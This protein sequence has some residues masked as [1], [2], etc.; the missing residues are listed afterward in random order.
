MHM[1]H[2]TCEAALRQSDASGTFFGSILIHLMCRP[3]NDAAPIGTLD[4]LDGSL[5]IQLS[6]RVGI[7]LSILYELHL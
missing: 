1:Y 5:E 7:L 3:G 6:C 2:T 4:Q